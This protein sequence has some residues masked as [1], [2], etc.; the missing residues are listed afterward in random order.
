[1]SDELRRYAEEMNLP[2]IIDLLNRLAAAEERVKRLKQTGREI[3][4]WLPVD[5]GNGEYIK[6]LTAFRTAL[7]DSND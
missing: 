4:E 2:A 3:I 1:M 6:D 5:S 7:G